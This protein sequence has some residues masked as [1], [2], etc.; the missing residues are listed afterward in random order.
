MDS[1]MNFVGLGVVY[2]SFSFFLLLTV[3]FFLFHLLHIQARVLNC[4]AQNFYPSSK[5][6][7]VR[8]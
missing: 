7:H 1:T 4:K 2:I 5:N 8:L 3:S 6:I